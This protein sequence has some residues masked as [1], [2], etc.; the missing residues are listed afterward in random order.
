[1][2]IVNSQN[3]LETKRRTKKEPIRR[4]WWFV[5]AINY[6]NKYEYGIISIKSIFF[7]KKDV[8]RKVRIKVEFVD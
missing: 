8:G 6:E 3:Y 5:K 2:V 7:N 4:N 1:M